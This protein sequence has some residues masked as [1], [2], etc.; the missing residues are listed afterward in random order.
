MVVGPWLS[1]GPLAAVLAA[2]SVIGATAPV[3]AAPGEAVAAAS[4]GYALQLGDDV[5]SRHGFALGGDFWLGLDD[6][7][8]LAASANGG[9]ASG[10]S[11]QNGFI[12]VGLGAV[13]ALDVFRW[14][15]WLEFLAVAA[16]PVDGVRP[17]GRVGFGID[18]LVTESWGLGGV[19]RATP[20][21]DGEQTVLL[22]FQLRVSHRLLL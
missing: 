14:V 20:L 18:Y 4:A 9:W 3:S 8:W 11:S 2:A 17:T 15:P 5:A 6:F 19:V 22:S 1:P 16:G 12:D 13:L 7:A 21:F 10:S